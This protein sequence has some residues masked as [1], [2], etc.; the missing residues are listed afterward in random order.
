MCGLDWR[1]GDA[2]SDPWLSLFYLSCSTEHS[3]HSP[4]PGGHPQHCSHRQENQK[5]K[6]TPLFG[7]S[8]GSHSP[9]HQ[10]GKGTGPAS[11]GAMS[12]ASESLSQPPTLFLHCPGDQFIHKARAVTLNPLP[13]EDLRVPT[14][15]TPDPKPNQVGC[16]REMKQVL[17]GGQTP[18]WGPQGL[19]GDT[20]A[21]TRRTREVS[22]ARMGTVSP[23]PT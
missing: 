15:I 8:Q 3:V 22:P 19:Y 18:K 12:G 21:A 23:V 13:N 2:H 9:W 1:Q 11:S 7:C 20:Y 4:P 14:R 6:H 17:E 5:T 10:K 16:S